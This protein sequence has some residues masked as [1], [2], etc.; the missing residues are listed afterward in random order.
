MQGDDAGSNYWRAAG[1]GAAGAAVALAAIAGLLLDTGAGDALEL[2]GGALVGAALLLVAAAVA[3]LLLRGIARAPA[4]SL[5][6]CFGAAAAV[7]T[8]YAVEPEPMLRVLAYPAGWEWPFAWPDP[9]GLVSLLLLVLAAAALAGLAA[10]LRRGGLAALA[11]RRGSLLAVGTVLVTAGAAAVVVTL[12]ADGHDP[13]PVDFR[14]LAGPAVPS[15]AMPANPSAPGPYEV[16]YLAYGAGPNPRRPVFGNDR[17]LESRTV[18]ATDLLPEWKDIKQAMRERYWGFGLDAAPLNGQVW[19]PRGAGPFPLFLVVHGNHTMEEYSDP[20]YAYLGELLASRGYVTVSV[21]EN[22]VNGTWSGDFRGREMPL[23]AW[24]LLEHLKLWR[25]WNATAGHPFAGRIDMARIALGGHSRGGEAISI[26]HAFNRLPHYPDDATVT[27]DYG[28]DIRALVSIAQI[29]RRY[30]RELELANVNFLALHGSYDGDVYS[31]HGLR[32]MNR[33]TLDAGSRAFKAG[34]YIHG[35]NHGQF[36]TV[37]GRED[38]GP[39]DAWRLNLAPLI[40]GEDQRRIAQVYISA[41]LDATL[42]E[43]P[44]YRP[45]FRDPRAG[46]AWLPDLVYVPQ[47]LDSS[48][49]PVARF[50]ED[51]DVRTASMA[52]AA[53]EASGFSVWREE[54]LRHRDELPQ[55]TSALVLGW[56]GGAQAEPVYSISLPDNLVVDTDALFAL[57]VSA[58]TER[59]VKGGDEDGDSDDEDQARSPAFVVELEDANGNRASVRSEHHAALAPPLRVRQLKN[60]AATEDEYKSDWEPVLQNFEVPVAE[61]R[62]VDLA[63]LRYLRLRFDRG[64]PGVVLIDDIGFRTSTGES[65]GDST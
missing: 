33:I 54:E 37:W 6:L 29:D 13:W 42:R 59:P 35:A 47:F 44:A 12:A 28:F 63:A 7:A 15:A 14:S 49:V 19:A 46:A 9:L 25:D 4:S 38:T 18:D 64:S 43:D 11:G 27:F 10:L 62:G 2:A 57:A 60:E 45:L 48:F 3:N 55:G 58:S 52:G 5:A 17:S 1:R 30:R 61:F 8:L 51:L 16:E 22:F 50:D 41:F 56:T 40:A 23:R 24:L 34:V 26:A 21:D 32:Q 20:G 39:P 31:Y 53:I 65:S 36:N